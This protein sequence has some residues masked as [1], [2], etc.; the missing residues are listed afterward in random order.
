[1]GLIRKGTIGIPKDR[2]TP[3]DTIDSPRKLQKFAESN[4]IKTCPLDVQRVAEKLDIQVLFHNFSDNEI[5]GTLEKN[6][7]G[8]W[9]IR[10]NDNHHPN[11]QRYTIAH[12]LG[13]YC[14]H[15]HQ[16]LFFEDQ[17]FFRG[18]EPTKTER[19]ANK[20]A[21]EIL[22]PEEKFQEFLDQN[23]TNVDE[24][25]KNFQVSTLALRV[26]A[27]ELGYSGHGL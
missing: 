10:V 26:R 25:A 8:T 5:S 11:R 9:I 7:E 21:S 15:R 2:Q 19:Q 18:L 23:I 1:M 16:E 27:K 14:L 24:L 6:D 4:G 3:I 22:M 20:F 12:E 13:H 17:I